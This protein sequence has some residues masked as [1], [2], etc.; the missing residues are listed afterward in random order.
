MIKAV[1][2]DFGQTLVDSADAFRAAEKEAQSRL[3]SAMASRPGAPSRADFLDRYRRIRKEF[4]LRSTFSRQAIWQAVY[5]YFNQKP[6]PE[7]FETW[8]NEYWE[9]VGSR[10]SPFPETVQVLEK[11]S[12]GYQL[13]LVTNTQGQ[14]SSGNHR[15]TLFPRLER[16]FRV[17]I[18]AGASGIPPKPA[19][20]P[21]Q[22]CLEKL[23]VLPH[24]A[25]FVGDDWRIDVCGAKNAGIRP[26]WLQHHS[27]KRNWPVVD[28]DFPVIA[29]LNDLFDLL[30]VL[31]ES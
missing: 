22:R 7:R 6:D 30:D 2:F 8:E 17:I 1:M 24:E 25:I 3:F 19:R 26:V 11:L 15:L 9:R 4:H 18:V 5:G 10:T 29:R 20:E 28:I 27:V 12:S 13:A 16:F 23:N 21:F 14:K 31:Q